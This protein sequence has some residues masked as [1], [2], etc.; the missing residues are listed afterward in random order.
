MKT[1]YPKTRSVLVKKQSSQIISLRSLTL[2]A[3]AACVV[4]TSLSA[5][6]YYDSNDGAIGSIGG[7]YGYEHGGRSDGNYGRQDGRQDGRSRRGDLHD[8]REVQRLVDLI[9]QA[10][11]F[12]Y[13][14]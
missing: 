3:L 8:Y 12:R 13:A 11:L 4:T 2:A 6:A 14:D 7:G 10:A 9:Y 1:T 5:N